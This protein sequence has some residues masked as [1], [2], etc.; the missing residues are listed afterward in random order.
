MKKFTKLFP[1]SGSSQTGAIHPQELAAGGA[2]ATEDPLEGTLETLPNS[3]PHLYVEELPPLHY[4][5]FP[6]DT[7]RCHFPSCINFTLAFRKR[8]PPA[9]NVTP[10]SYLEHDASPHRQLNDKKSKCSRQEVALH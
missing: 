7:N 10:L 5:S 8:Q 9:L 4:Q 3:L 2:R 6:R 1:S